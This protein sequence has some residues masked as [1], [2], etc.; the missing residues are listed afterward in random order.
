[1]ILQCSIVTDE[2]SRRCVP[3]ITATPRAHRDVP[4]MTAP[5]G[6]A[7]GVTTLRVLFVNAHLIAGR[8]DGSW[9]LVDAG[10]PGSADR[11]VRAAEERFGPGTA[12]SAIVLTHGHFDHVGALKALLRRWD[13]PVL[14]HPQELPYITG[15]AAY[16]P[17]DPSV[18]GGAMSFLS[19]LIPR[20]PIDL[21]PHATALPIDG[22]VPGLPDW[23]WIA[24]PGHSPGHVSLFREAD[25]TLIAGDAVVT[26]K[27]QSLLSALTQRPEL[28]GPMPYFTL[29]WT[30][31]RRS[32]ERLAELQPLVLT[33]G[34]GPPMEGPGVAESLDWLARHFDEVAV[35]RRG[36]YVRQP[37]RIRPDGSAELPP[38]VP[39]AT[40]AILASIGVGALVGLVLAGRGGGRSELAR[41]R[42]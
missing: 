40:W 23:R 38:P 34:H 11:I 28:H 14:A 1:V 33:T 5:F 19:R 12:P 30:Q 9:V 17:P 13:V 29:D 36:R 21:G 6:G 8:R 31:A 27:Q 7:R 25:R 16:P 4:R 35:P 20:G 2:W 3:G 18:G 32:V 41:H 26:T 39:D 22:S 42:R 10:L 15:R 37:V 24:T